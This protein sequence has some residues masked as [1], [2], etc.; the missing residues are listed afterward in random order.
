LSPSYTSI[1]SGISFQGFSYWKKHASVLEPELDPEID[2]VLANSVYFA[3]YSSEMNPARIIWARAVDFGH[4][5]PERTLPAPE[6][7]AGIGHPIIGYVGALDSERLDHDI[8]AFLAKAQPSW[9]IVLVGRK[10]RLPSK[11]ASS[12]SNIIFWA[13]SLSSFYPLT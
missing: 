12:D 8:I 9:N 3:E 11:P 7:I 1:I 2:I 6:D 5:D 4:F 10:M 13:P